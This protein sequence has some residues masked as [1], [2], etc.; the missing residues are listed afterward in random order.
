MLRS[1]A[2][3]APAPD[4]H[5]R[6][7]A[8]YRRLTLAMTFAGFSTFSLLYAI[9]PLLPLLAGEYDLS[10]EAASLAVSLATGPLAV[11]ILVAGVVSDRVGR[12]PLMVWA[13]LSAGLLTGAAALAP[14]WIVLL[15]LRLL[16]GVALAGVPAGRD[17]LCRGRGERRS[18]GRGHGPLHRG[19]RGGGHGRPAGRQPLRRGGPVGD[20]RSA[21]SVSSVWRWRRRSAGWRPRRAV[22]RRAGQAA[23]E[24]WRCC[25]TPRSGSSTAK[26]SC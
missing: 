12:R 9:Q 4:G 5:A 18:G 15:S 6:G 7:S 1:A 17:G 24:Q 25:A 21:R 3:G 2:G 22:S 19:Q 10:A 23:A 13:M 26:V 11:G 16:T 20:G 8:A 14:G